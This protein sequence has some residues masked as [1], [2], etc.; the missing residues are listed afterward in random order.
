LLARTSYASDGASSAV[1]H[2]DLADCLVTVE[3]ITYV[4]MI[5]YRDLDDVRVKPSI[6]Q[7]EFLVKTWLFEN[8]SVT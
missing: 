8:V 1:V 7:T 3:G 6:W 4:D 2:C 5:S